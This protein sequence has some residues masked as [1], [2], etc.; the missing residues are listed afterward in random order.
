MI[1]LFID[2]TDHI[3]IDLFVALDNSNKI[4]VSS[5]KERLIK[6]NEGLSPDSVVPYTFVF[7]RPNY[8]DNMT[9]ISKSVTSDGETTNIDG[10]ILRYER[11]CELISSWTITDADG[12]NV[13]CNRGNVDKLNPI[14]ADAVMSRFEEMII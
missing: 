7:R 4:I 11:F 5:D 8:K 14:L 1:N 9:V 12:K 6:G 10:A 3:T 2:P 13:P